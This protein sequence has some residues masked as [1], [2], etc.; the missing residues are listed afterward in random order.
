MALIMT[1]IIAQNVLYV[2][3]TRSNIL[4]LVLNI[5]IPFQIEYSVLLPICRA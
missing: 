2:A 4:T 1:Q 3:Y 5:R